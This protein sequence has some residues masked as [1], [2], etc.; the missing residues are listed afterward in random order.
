[1]FKFSESDSVE[2][3]EAEKTAPKVQF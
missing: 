2:A 1:L 3:T